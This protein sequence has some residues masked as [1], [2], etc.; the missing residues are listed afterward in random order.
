[1]IIIVPCLS[2]GIFNLLSGDFDG[3]EAFLSLRKT[4]RE[5]SEPGVPSSK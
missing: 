1:M 5:T 4:K 3:L 2:H